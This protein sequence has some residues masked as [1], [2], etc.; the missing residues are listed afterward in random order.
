MLYSFRSSCNDWLTLEPPEGLIR[1][2]FWQTKE[3]VES[4]VMG[5]YHTLAAMDAKLFKYGEMRGDLVKADNNIAGDERL[6]MEG[7]I[8]P[9]NSL[10]DWTDFYK[11][12][13]YC[14]EVSVL[15][16]RSS[17][18]GQDIYRLPVE[19]LS[20]RSLFYTELKLFLPGTHI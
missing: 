9:D 16:T 17:G 15:C 8:Y 10:C 19:W 5:A 20:L 12:I 13:N 18:Q 1:E 2:E 7:T 6:I 3:D 11:V 4:A 14:N